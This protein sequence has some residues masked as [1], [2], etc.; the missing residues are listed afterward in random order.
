MRIEAGLSVQ[1]IESTIIGMTSTTSQRSRRGKD[2]RHTRG[3]SRESV[4]NGRGG[5]YVGAEKEG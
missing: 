2:C 3:L 4:G 1:K 5:R